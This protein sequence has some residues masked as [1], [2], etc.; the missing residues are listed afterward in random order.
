MAFG[1]GARRSGKGKG[2]RRRR[3]SGKGEGARRRDSKF[4]KKPEGAAKHLDGAFVAAQGALGA[5]SCRGLVTPDLSPLGGHAHAVKVFQNM[6]KREKAMAG[7]WAVFYHSY[8]TPALTY[9]VQAAVAKVL[10]HFGAK[11]GV[12]PRLL[13]EPFKNVPDAAAA[14]KEF[15]KWVSD[16]IPAHRYD[17]NPAFISVGICCSTSLVSI[18]PEA[19]PTKVFLA[20]GYGVKPITIEV[21]EKLLRDC[22]TPS[23]SVSSL[24]KQILDLASKYG[25][26]EA[27]G[28]GLKGHLLQIFIHRSCV[29]H[30]AYASQPYGILDTPRHPIS[31]H[32]ETKG[33][34]VGQARLVVNPIAFMRA[35]NVRLHVCSADETFHKNR[36]GFQR[37]LFK[38]LAPILGAP[39]VRRKAATGIYGGTLP[40]W[41]RDLGSKGKAPKFKAR[42]FKARGR[43]TGKGEGKDTKKRKGDG[44]R[45]GKGK[46]RRRFRFARRG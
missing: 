45:K 25:L 19:T 23:A 26:P 20:G 13:K 39:E 34:I 37:A 30:W 31:K 14:L 5:Q 17:H 46:E 24:A 22:G 16:P 44:H 36:K 40:S 12:L 15:P 3:R 28:A 11:H 9:E 8:N 2:A 42:R 35:K 1:K 41:W 32:L 4:K 27:T 21:L 18:D 43:R 29:D 10:F 7:K 6:L 38:A 33:P